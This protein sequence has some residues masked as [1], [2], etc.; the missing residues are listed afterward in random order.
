MVTAARA[1]RFFFLSFLS[2]VSPLLQGCQI[3]LF[4]PSL[5][6]GGLGDPVPAP[7]EPQASAE[8][9]REG[10]WGCWA[11]ILS[12]LEMP[13]EGVGRLAWQRRAAGWRGVER[14]QTNSLLSFY[15]YF[16]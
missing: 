8:E 3:G 10:A 4:T 6:F 15:T 16:Y 5:W 7:L 14:R 1:G 11:F 9:E 2:S 13:W 12:C